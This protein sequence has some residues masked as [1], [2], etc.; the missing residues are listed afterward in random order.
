MQCDHDT[1]LFAAW[2]CFQDFELFW[3]YFTQTCKA[4]YKSGLLCS[5]SKN[6]VALLLGI[7]ILN[8]SAENLDWR[9]YK[10]GILSGIILLIQ[11]WRTCFWKASSYF[12]LPAC[13]VFSSLFRGIISHFTEI[14]R[15]YA[16]TDSAIMIS[17]LSVSHWSQTGE[18]QSG[19]VNCKVGEKLSGLALVLGADTV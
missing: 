15:G 5:L 4:A 8:L 16:P 12:N 11:S 18:V 17:G 7:S 2:S 19:W 9:G 14:I 3:N 13:L 6:W 1:Q 10:N